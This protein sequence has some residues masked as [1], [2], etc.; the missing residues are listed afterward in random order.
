MGS[1]RATTTVA[2]RNSS[3]ATGTI[4]RT[5]TCG[6]TRT[7]RVTRRGAVHNPLADLAWLVR[8]Q[9]TCGLIWSDL[10]YKAVKCVAPCEYY[11]VC[12]VVSYGVFIPV[13]SDSAK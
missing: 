10:K 6:R 7:R 13:F 1:T 3:S 9:R 5:V 4:T 11:V 8:G 12:S 2:T